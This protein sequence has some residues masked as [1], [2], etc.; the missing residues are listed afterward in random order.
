MDFIED[1]EEIDPLDYV[2]SCM[3]ALGV[4]LN[5]LDPDGTFKGMPS[6]ALFIKIMREVRKDFRALSDAILALREERKEE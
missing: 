6:E 3:Q 2:D 1:T 5:L 4:S